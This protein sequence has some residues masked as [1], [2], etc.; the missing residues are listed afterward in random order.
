MVTRDDHLLLVKY[1]P[2]NC[3][4]SLDNLDIDLLNRKVVATPP[5]YLLIC[6]FSSWSIDQL[7]CVSIANSILILVVNKT[8]VPYTPTALV[9]LLVK[10]LAMNITNGQ[11]F[12]HDFSYQSLMSP[13]WNFGVRHLKFRL[14]DLAFCRNIAAVLGSLYILRLLW[15]QLWQLLGGFCAFFLAPWGISRINLKKYGPWAGG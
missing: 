2:K 1:W 7:K 12:G 6:W 11:D 13:L 9:V 3:A 10:E 8:W 5:L 15:C 14:S 4:Q